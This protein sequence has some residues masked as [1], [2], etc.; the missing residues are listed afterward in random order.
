MSYLD[1]LDTVFSSVLL[2]NDSSQQPR[3]RRSGKGMRQLSLDFDS[4]DGGSEGGGNQVGGTAGNDA[5]TSKE[6]EPPLGSFAAR[7]SKYL[8]LQQDAA[9]KGKD[10]KRHGL[11][12]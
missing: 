1:R 5:D 4:A 7:L 10:R 6:P 11:D 2:D 8:D 3:A 9:R 12:R